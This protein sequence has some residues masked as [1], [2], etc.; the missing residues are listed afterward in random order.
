MPPKSR[1]LEPYPGPRP[2]DKDERSIFFGRD[3]EIADLRDLCMS[4][5]VVVLY[6]QSGAGKSSLVRAGLRPALVLRFINT[7]TYNLA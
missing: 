5:Q 6:S 2:F 3:E 7:I 4:Y 1:I